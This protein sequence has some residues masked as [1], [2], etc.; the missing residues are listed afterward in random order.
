MRGLKM[1]ILCA[2]MAA[3]CACAGGPPPSET[4]DAP[5]EDFVVIED[6]AL[7]LTEIRYLLITVIDDYALFRDIEPHMILWDGQIAGIPARRY[8][9]DRALEMAVAAYVTQI[10]AA[11]LGYALTEEEEDAIDWE[12]AMEI[13]ARGGREALFDSPRE[14][15]VYRFYSY[16]VPALREKM[17][18]DLFG[19]DG[20]YQLNG[21]ALWQ[22]YRDNYISAA[23]IFLSGTDPYGEPLGA[24][25]LQ[26]Q[27]SVADALRRAAAAAEDYEGFFELVREHD[28]SYYMMIYPTGM[29]VPHGMFGE[30]FDAA[31]SALETG[32]VSDVVAADDGFY[33]ILR[34][35]EDVE[36]FEDNR[37]YIWYYCAYEAFFDKIEEW[38]RELSIAVGEG[39]WNLDVL[40]V[41]AAG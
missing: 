33:I 1:L 25:D 22:Y 20:P 3:L 17:L 27:R 18:D 23:Y 14:E 36:W 13:D 39:F 12:I 38:G 9:L 41:T 11:E 40:E 7:D 31:L 34:L 35:P 28:Q 26:I 19:H 8:F 2:A 16:T 24:D 37:E 32:M 29:P 15:E 5:E 4:P 10:K 6:L 30:A 21:A